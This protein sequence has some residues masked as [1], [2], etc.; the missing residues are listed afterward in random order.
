M[1][2]LKVYPIKI[3]EDKLGES[4]KDIIPDL[5][6]F[7]VLLGKIRSGKSVLLQNLYLSPRFFGDDYDV[8]ISSRGIAHFKSVGIGVEYWIA[9]ESR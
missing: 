5:V 3:D 1:T 9:T 6:H 4:K 7:N 8:K 2:D